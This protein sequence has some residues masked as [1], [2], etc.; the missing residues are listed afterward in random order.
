MSLSLVNK[1]MELLTAIEN[2]DRAESRICSGSG[3]SGASPGHCLD[4]LALLHLVPL[5]LL[6]LLL[7][8]LYVLIND[9]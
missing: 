6:L 4:C 7:L 8:L 2:M 9:R 1:S 5:L 3:R